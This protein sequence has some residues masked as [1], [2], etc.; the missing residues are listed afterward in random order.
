M[1]HVRTPPHTVANQFWR[2]SRVLCSLIAVA[3]V[4]QA[5]MATPRSFPDVKATSENGRFV[6]EAKSPDNA[7]E[8]AFFQ[9]NFTLTLT[10]MRTKAVMWQRKQAKDEG[11][12]AWL[13]WTMAN[14]SPFTQAET[15]YCCLMSRASGHCYL[16]S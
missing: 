10:D 5:A 15:S 6:F 3:L 11:P 12:R 14:A 8:F 13:S 2:V 16:I 4:S 7:R 9:S 1:T